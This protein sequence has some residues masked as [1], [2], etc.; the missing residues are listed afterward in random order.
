MSRP[1]NI[2]RCSRKQL[3]GTVCAE[4]RGSSAALQNQS[5]RGRSRGSSVL[6]YVMPQ[7]SQRPFSGRIAGSRVVPTDRMLDF[8]AVDE[9]QTNSLVKTPA[10]TCGSKPCK[11]S[12]TTVAEG[13]C[14][15]DMKV[16][17]R[18]SETLACGSKRKGPAEGFRYFDPHKHK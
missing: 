18:G 8:R 1:G 7:L 14:G 15:S 11:L 6:K 4:E 3:H 10:R 17:A 13:I 9:T 5:L 16:E 12:E 2:N